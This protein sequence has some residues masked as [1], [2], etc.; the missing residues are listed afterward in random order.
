[1]SELFYQLKIAEEREARSNRNYASVALGV[2]GIEKRLAEIDAQHAPLCNL[3]N[4][5]R[6]ECYAVAFYIV[7]G[8]WPAGFEYLAAKP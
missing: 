2:A 6:D 8:R 1:M 7:I 3:K 4:S 5:Q